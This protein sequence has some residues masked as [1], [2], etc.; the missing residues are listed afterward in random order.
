MGLFK[1]IKD[2]RGLAKQAKKIQEKQLADAGY[3]PGT[4]GNLH[5]MS[6]M[7]AG[8]SQQLD[9][10]FQTQGD[11][12]RI[13]AEGLDGEATIVG[14]G[15]PPRAAALFNLMIDL[16]VR[17]PGQTPYRVANT[18]MVPSSAQLAEGV[19]VPVKVDQTNPANV[20]IDWANAPQKP[21]QGQIR[22]ADPAT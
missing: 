2:L 7:I 5:Q 11:Q 15:V 9:D 12:T 18:Y 22:P 16:E 19:V 17:V 3:E 21:V 6:D 8:V 20:A 13:L 1:S 4:R 10:L 14:M